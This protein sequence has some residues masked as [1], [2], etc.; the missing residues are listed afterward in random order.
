MHPDFSHQVYK[1]RKPIFSL[2]QA[3]RAWYAK[4][5]NKLLSSGF[6]ISI[7]DT[8]VF[9]MHNNMDCLFILIYID[10][11]IVI[12]SSPSLILNFIASLK[13]EFPVKD[14]L[15]S[16]H[17]FLGIEVHQNTSSTFLSRSKYIIDLFSKTNMHHSKSVSTPTSSS[18]KLTLLD[19][20]T[21]E[22]LTYIVL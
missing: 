17:D 22:D 8:S 2:K 11:I 21:F 5:S 12:R 19:G 18:E 3:P 4:F 9:I 7:S 6:H 16:L 20:P 10:D 1:L 15:G 14:F 13:E